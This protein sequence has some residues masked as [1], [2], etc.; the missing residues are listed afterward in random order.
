MMPNLLIVF[1]TTY[2]QT[3]KIAARMRDALTGWGCRVTLSRVGDL[4][5]VDLGAYDGVI[6]G[7]SIIGGKHQRAVLDFVRRNV[8]ALNAMPSAFFSVSGSAASSDPKQRQ[9]ARALLDAF[10]ARTGWVPQRSETIGGAIAFTKYPFILR[11]VMK[12]ISKRNGG[13]TDTTRDHEMTDWAQVDRF[14]RDFEADAARGA[15][16]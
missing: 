11:F 6:V 3:A 1:G 2:G 16:V 13:P 14:A 15:P 5:A 7:A 12:L 4:G 10:L 9:E 8:A